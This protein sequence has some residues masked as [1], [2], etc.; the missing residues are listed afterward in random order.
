[1]NRRLAAQRVA[2]RHKVASFNSQVA[3]AL[4]K[5]KPQTSAIKSAIREVGL[6]NVMKQAKDR[7]VIKSR[8]MI[9]K[10]ISSKP[11][12]AQFKDLVEIFENREE[13]ARQVLGEDP[14]SKKAGLLTAMGAPV[15]LIKGLSWLAASNLGMA[16]LILGCASILAMG[17]ILGLLFMESLPYMF[18]GFLKFVFVKFPLLI[19]KAVMAPVKFLSDLAS[20]FDEKVREEEKVLDFEEMENPSD[21]EEVEQFRRSR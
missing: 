16:V 19:F 15:W 14:L 5:Q 20:K 1:M 4:K 17:Y 9:L 13:I 7:K 10:G 21:R 12:K 18:V 3:S 8:D 2:R 6:S 11:L